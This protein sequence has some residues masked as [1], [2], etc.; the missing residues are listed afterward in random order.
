[1]PSN[2]YDY[3]GRSHA[4]WFGDIN[5]AGRYGWYEAAFM[6]S[7][8]SHQRSRLAP[9]SL[10]PGEASAKALWTGMAEYQMAWPFTPLASQSLEDFID[11][12][13]G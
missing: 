2:R 3:D 8:F 10:P 12:W 4:L 9:F 11:R 1:M 13:L 6:L 7:P 5:K